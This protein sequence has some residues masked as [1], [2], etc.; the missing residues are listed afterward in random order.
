MQMLGVAVLA[1]GVAYFFLMRRRRFAAALAVAVATPLLTLAVVEYRLP[2]LGGIGATTQHNVV[3]TR[4]APNP[5]QR[6]ILSA[7]YDTKTELLD[8]VARTPLQLLAIPMFGL[9]LAAPL[10]GIFRRMRGQ[11]PGRWERVGGRPDAS[12]ASLASRF[13]PSTVKPSKSCCFTKRCGCRMKA[14][15]ARFFQG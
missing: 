13:S 6:L 5:R 3:A 9:L 4:S 12:S 7:H 15:A 10:R 1:L 11:E 8:H 2:A 14:T